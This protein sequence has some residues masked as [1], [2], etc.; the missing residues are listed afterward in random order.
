MSQRKTININEPEHELLKSLS[1]YYG[2]PMVA[3]VGL[4]VRELYGSVHNVHNTHTNDVYN[5]HTP[6]PL[7]MENAQKSVFSSGRKLEAVRSVR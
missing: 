7:P 4:L 2:V 3:I 5:M 6:S 1:E